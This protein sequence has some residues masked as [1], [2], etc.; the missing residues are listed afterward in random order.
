[1]K[2][3]EIKISNWRSIKDICL[4]AQDLMI[5]IGQNNHG[6][7]NIISSILFFFGEIK[8]S[9][10]DF[11]NMSDKLFVEIKFIELDENDKITFK[12]YLTVNNEIRVRKTAYTG[13]SFEYAGYIENPVEECLK[14]KNATNYTKR[15][16]AELEIFKEFLPSDGRLN[17]EVILKAQQQYISQ[18][19]NNL[20]FNY[21][22]EETAFLG[23]K[24]VASSI[25]GNVYFLPALKDVKED[26][27]SKDG[28]IFSRLYMDI[29]KEMSSNNQNWIETKTQLHGLFNILNPID[30]DGNRNDARPS[31]IANFEKL[32]SEELAN[33]NTSVNIEILSPDVDNILRQ[34]TNIW[35][36]DGVKTDLSRK[37]HGLQRALAFALINII[38]KQTLV[39]QN[40]ANLSSSRQVS[41]SNY[42]ILEEPEL[43]LHPHAQR[44]LLDSLDTLSKNNNQVVLCTHS[45]ALIDLEKYKSIYIAT[46]EED[47]NRN[48]TIKQCFDEIFIDD[49]KQNFNLSYWINADR[50]ELFFAKKVILLEGQTEKAIIP[51][52]AKKLEVFRYDYTLIDCGSKD[53]I[54]LYIKLLHKFKIPYLVVYDKDNQSYKKQDALN[55]ANISTT[56]ILESIDY[57]LGKHI[58][59]VN[60]I[61]EELGLPKG[62]SSKPYMAIQTIANSD[63]IIKNSFKD[64][65]IEI[66]S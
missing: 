10:S 45:S 1:M 61:E 27:T 2:M 54:P 65:I 39:K 37:G 40:I 62:T 33:W 43:Y 49:E 8:F 28:S 9:D 31:E 19:F 7:S 17:K 47:V 46:K 25:F 53:N 3:D 38:A 60:D 24:S 32:L 56:K 44:Q 4:Q 48:T 29:I 50:S 51:K 13:G 58:E 18:N 64:K 12:K 57:N 59:L 20:E 55:S 66:F 23:L 14:E 22:L 16:E 42:F 34:N 35:I 41:I 5:I 52:L 11:N 6:K 30:T 36:D 21:E 15:A 26:F 63:Y